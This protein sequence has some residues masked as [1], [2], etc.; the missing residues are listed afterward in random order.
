M[1]LQE[2]EIL[3]EMIGPDDALFRQTVDLI[4]TKGRAGDVL[5]TGDV[6]IP[7][8]CQVMIQKADA[9]KTQLDYLKKVL[10]KESKIE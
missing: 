5:L 9:F 2:G 8:L 3:S 10:D 6:I 4:I 7:I 1:S